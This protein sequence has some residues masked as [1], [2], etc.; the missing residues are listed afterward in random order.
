[1]S[2]EDFK[3][4]YW[5]EWAHRAW[6]RGLGL[7]FALPL[8]GF[9]AAGWVTRPL[10]R[11]LGL[12]LAL[13]GG[14]GLVGWWMVKSGLEARGGRNGGWA[15]GGLGRAARRSVR[16]RA[17][18]RHHPHD[19]AITRTPSPSP[20]HT[21]H[22]HLHHHPTSFPPFTGAQGQMGGAPRLPHPPKSR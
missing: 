1:M 11:R 7:A 14:Q 15:V 17:R 10:G 4:I 8:A 22:H 13:G 20:H 16:T 6:G 5:M 3:F 19:L 12:L 9:V 21:H 18:P 2:L